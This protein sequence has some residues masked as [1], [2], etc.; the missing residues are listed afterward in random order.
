MTD[1]MYTY[2]CEPEHYKEIEKK[3]C[4]KKLSDSQAALSNLLINKSERD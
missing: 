2:F 1:E 3:N 4:N